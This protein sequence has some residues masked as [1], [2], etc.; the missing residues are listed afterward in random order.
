MTIE[1]FKEAII[2]Y[3]PTIFMVISVIANYLKTFKALTSNVSKIEN[4]TTLKKLNKEIQD[5]QFHMVQNS[6][7]SNDL[8]KENAELKAEIVELKELLIK[9]N[10][11]KD[12][13]DT[14]NEEIQEA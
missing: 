10:E 11:V 2:L 3:A 8:K 1:S 9:Y 4:S 7:Y 13:K 14:N 6:K 5:L 12:E